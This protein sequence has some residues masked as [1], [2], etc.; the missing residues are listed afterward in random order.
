[1]HYISTYLDTLPRLQNW[2]ALNSWGI[3]H[4]GCKHLWDVGVLGTLIAPQSLCLFLLAIPMSN[5]LF[6]DI[7]GPKHMIILTVMESWMA[8]GMRMNVVPLLFMSNLITEGIQVFQEKA[9]LVSIIWPTQCNYNFLFT[10]QKC[11]KD[12]NNIY[13]QVG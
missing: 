5:T 2:T 12:V 1:M 6:L 13:R 9:F 7:F 10:L 3:S 11:K 8:V 4:H